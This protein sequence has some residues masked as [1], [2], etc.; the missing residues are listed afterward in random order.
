MLDSTQSLSYSANAG[1]K[2]KRERDISD[3]LYALG[4]G[5]V[6]KLTIWVEVHVASGKDDH[7]KEG[8]IIQ[9]KAIKSTSSFDGVIL[10]PTQSSSSLSSGE[11]S[12]DK[13]KQDTSTSLFRNIA[14][15]STEQLF[16]VGN[17]ECINES[18]HNSSHSFES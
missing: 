4:D 7:S 3:D 15:D 14:I 8:G 11:G 6:V 1:S 2:D 13:N 17:K 12:K 9:A 10:D 18:K 5:E 16:S